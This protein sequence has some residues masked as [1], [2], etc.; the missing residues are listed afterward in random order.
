[1]LVQVLCYTEWW[2]TT[3]EYRDLCANHPV[4]LLD[5]WPAW[6]FASVSSNVTDTT[7]F[8][9][10]GLDPT[11]EHTLTLM[12]LGSD[13]AFNTITVFET[14]ET[15]GSPVTRYVL[16]AITAELCSITQT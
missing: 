6:S 14:D 12:D 13:F 3:Y 8:Y 1:M 16:L 4:Q 15:T 5:S 7:L 10:G 9:Q 11:Q 2:A